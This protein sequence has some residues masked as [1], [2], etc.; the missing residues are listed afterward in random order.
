MQ[1][2]SVRWHRGRLC[3]EWSRDVDMT[4]RLCPEEVSRGDADDRERTSLHVDRAPDGI[5][6]AAKPPKPEAMADDRDGLAIQFGQRASGKGVDA[7][8]R[9]IVARHRLGQRELGLTG[10]A[11]VRVL[12]GTERSEPG[13]HVV[14]FGEVRGSR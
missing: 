3:G 10:Y 11:D 5:R 9:V 2:S 7:E 6:I 13:K 1:P 12:S 8:H 4:S 14:A